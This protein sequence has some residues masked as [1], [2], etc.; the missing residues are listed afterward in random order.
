MLTPCSC[1]TVLRKKQA[2]G[3]A[4]NRK[5][6]VLWRRVPLQSLCQLRLSSQVLC[7]VVKA[8]RC[9]RTYPLDARQL[10]AEAGQVCTLPCPSAT[11]LQ[12]LPNGKLPQCS[13]DM[14]VRSSFC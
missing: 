5:K 1:R 3:H 12:E 8:V 13:S 6:P 7:M 10:S 2:P 9:Y 4:R 11:W 14:D